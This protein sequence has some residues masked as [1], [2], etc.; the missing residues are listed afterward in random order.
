MDTLRGH[1]D[2][3]DCD[4]EVDTRYGQFPANR[5]TPPQE[6]IAAALDAMLAAERPLIFAGGGMI[7]SGAMAEVQELAELLDVPVTT[8]YM[9]KGTMAEDH[10]LCLGP[11]G[12]HCIVDDLELIKVKKT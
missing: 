6:D 4:F 10:P 7:A 12:P 5:L 1:Q 8:T 11:F 2:F 9:G 3:A